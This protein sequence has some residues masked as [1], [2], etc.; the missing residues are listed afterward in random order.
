MRA[1]YISHTGMTEPLGQAQ[2]LPYLEGVV[3]SGVELEILSYER[4][5]TAETA[6]VE[7]R[8]RLH[9]QGIRWRPLVRSA[10]PRLGRKV[11]ES[12]YGLMLGLARALARRPTVIHARSYLPTA[13][14]D[15]IA[16]TVPG[17]KL[18]FDCRGM[19]GDEYVDAGY[20]TRDRLEYQL[21]KRYEV[22]AFR[23]TDG[24]VVLTNAL[25]SWLARKG[26]VGAE[27]HVE[28]IPCCVDT[29][30][31]RVDLDARAAVRRELGIEGERPLCV[32]SGSLG[33]WYREPDMGA[34]VGALARLGARPKFLVLSHNDTKLLVDAAIA[35]GLPPEDVIVKSAAPREM[36]RYLAAC[37]VGLSFIQSCFAKMGSS[38]TKVAEYLAA[39]ALAVL[40]GDIGDQAELAEEKQSCVVLSAFDDFA[41]DAA[42]RR[43]VSLLREPY[44]SRASKAREA[45]TRRLGLEE[46]GVPRYVRMYETLGRR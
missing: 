26:A 30:R 11:F 8:E 45:A 39:G 22:R 16:S 35:A 31:F 27:T 38:P 40:S 1:L 36:S 20:W 37:D 43:T 29:S 21:L 5:G 44:A 2:V 18:L 10:S 17:A 4:A 28:V 9:R 3:R 34:F 19:L 14:A 33:S 6:I 32:Y 41:I 42:A 15:V 46:V 12:G 24:L 13:V 7:L 25:R 23:R